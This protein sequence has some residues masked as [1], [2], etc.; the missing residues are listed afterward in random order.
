MLYKLRKSREKWNGEK[1]DGKLF[2]YGEQGVGDEILFSSILSD[3]SKEHVTFQLRLCPK[4]IK[5]GEIFVE[6]NIIIRA[7]GSIEKL[8]KFTRDNERAGLAN[9]A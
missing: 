1:F 2:V 6:K 3:L 4:G 5:I 7:R 8:L 9:D